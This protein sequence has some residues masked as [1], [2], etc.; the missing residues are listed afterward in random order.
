MKSLKFLLALLGTLS[1]LSIAS[2]VDAQRGNI[3]STRAIQ[4]LEDL[5]GADGEIDASVLAAAALPVTVSQVLANDDVELSFGTDADVVFEYNNTG[6][7]F[8][9]VHNGA[10]YLFDGFPAASASGDVWNLTGTAA[11][12]N[13]S[14][15][16]NL[17]DFDLTNA[18]HTG[19]GNFVNILNIGAITGDA[20]SN[21]YAINIGNL[22]GTSGAAGE[23][24]NAINVGTGW[25]NDLYLAD[26]T[27]LITGAGT[28]TVSLADSFTVNPDGTASN[29]TF[30]LQDMDTASSSIN[31]LA[32][33][34]TVGIMDGS[35]T[36]SAAVLTL[37]NA[38]HTGT[39][40]TVNLLNIAA[41][42]GDANSNLYAI[43]IGNLTG[44]SGA[45]GELENAINVGTGWDNDLYL[46]DTTALITGAGTLTVSLAD[47]FTVNPDGTASNGTFIL[48]D[49][50]T[51]SASIN[52]LAYSATV[53][54]MNGS[55]T[56]NGQLITLTNADHTSTGN[57]VNLLNIAAI[58]GDAE[59]NLNAINIGALTGTSGAAGEVEAAVNFGAGWDFDLYKPSGS[60]IASLAGAVETVAGPPSAGASG[61]VISW[62]ATLTAMDNSDTVNFLSVAPTNANHTGSSNV[63]NGISLGNITGDAEATEQGLLLGTGWD[64]DIRFADTNALIVI[65]DTGKIDINDSGGNQVFTISDVNAN[66][67]AS[68][69]SQIT[70]TST[71]GFNIQTPTGVLNGSDDVAGFTWW[72]FTDANHSG[73]ANYLS[74]FRAE[75]ITTPDTHAIHSALRVSTGW[76]AI[77]MA[78]VKTAAWGAA[79][80][81]PANEV[82]FFLDESGANCN[83]TARLSDGTEILVVA[84]VVA[85]DCP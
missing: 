85:G 65:A 43:N 13:G 37:T 5:I 64:T 73:A 50:D 62:A 1:I 47:S 57:T 66:G 60:F 84:L 44:T 71:R 80:N 24:E 77:I 9:I 67:L 19:T 16:L 18:N 76:D 81:P 28:L 45:A 14:D 63:L 75:A 23:L 29:G 27:A 56:L 51:A 83:L 35:D 2:V 12:A 4:T 10:T 78:Q 42:T 11:A 17:L 32:Y 54:A 39:G 79:E 30:I 6:D 82:A 38:N 53:G 69:S 59:S 68:L 20:N 26:T 36:L 61:T 41:I 15:T 58:T 8:V 52:G 21:L 40:N 48:Q 3:W 74:A 70:V 46:A 33:S 22:T 7:Q 25:D 34:A 31:G 72:A 55:D 49:M